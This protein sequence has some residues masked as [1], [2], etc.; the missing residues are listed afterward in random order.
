MKCRAGIHYNEATGAY[1]Q[2]LQG[3]YTEAHAKLHPEQAAARQV[4]LEAA[5]PWRDYHPL[6]DTSLSVNERRR[7]ELARPSRPVISLLAA[8]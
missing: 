5:G 4:V 6:A 8:S 3:H 2:C 7:M 1:Q